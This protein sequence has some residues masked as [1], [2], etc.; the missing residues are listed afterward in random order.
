MAVTFDKT[1]FLTEYPEFALTEARVPGC[2][3]R[4]FA[5]ACTILG[6]T[7]A[8]PV[9]EAQRADMLGMLTAHFLQLFFGVGGKLPQGAVGRVSS[10]GEGSVNVSLDM[11]P[12][13]NS[14]A[15]Y[16][17]TQYGATYWQMSRAYRTAVYVAPDQDPAQVFL[18][19]G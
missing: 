4:C 6:N 17:Q 16:A 10:A 11:G 9:P 2:S 1:S 15:W 19:E 13:L 3:A 7:D 18:R 14:Q 5:R 8:S 12:V